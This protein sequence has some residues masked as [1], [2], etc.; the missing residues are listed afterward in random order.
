MTGGPERAPAAGG[1]NCVIS[2]VGENGAGPEKLKPGY[3]EEYGGSCRGPIKGWHQGGT[4]SEGT[5]R[6][7]NGDASG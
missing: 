7:L 3:G 1:N 2:V 6:W 5:I 4:S